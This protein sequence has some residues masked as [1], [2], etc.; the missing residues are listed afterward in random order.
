MNFGTWEKLPKLLSFEVV[1]KRSV[2]AGHDSE[3]NDIC[4]FLS[5]S[6]EAAS[7][8]LDKMRAI[9]SWESSSLAGVSTLAP[10]LISQE[11]VLKRRETYYEWECQCCEKL[12]RDGK[13]RDRS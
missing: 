11:K 5:E 6:W 9:S 2:G 7:V 13:D 4:N 12:W 3:R 8:Q 10:T 1:I